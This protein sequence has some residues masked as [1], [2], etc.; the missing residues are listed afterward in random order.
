MRDHAVIKSVRSHG[1][2]EG[3]HLFSG[4][5]VRTGVKACRQRSQP[6]PASR[7]PRLGTGRSSSATACLR[8]PLVG[9]SSARMGPA[10]IEARII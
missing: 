2:L 10:S 8:V 5:A 7:V 1:V 9:R 6:G 4:G 3:R